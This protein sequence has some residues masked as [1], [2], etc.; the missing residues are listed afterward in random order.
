MQTENEPINTFPIQ[1]FIKIVK[2][3]DA[4][5]SREIKLDIQS[6]KNL[7]FTLGMVLARLNGDL[8]KLLVSKSNNDDTVLQISVDGGKSW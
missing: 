2:S 5:Q 1:N 8:E 3:A 6:A 7:A 4:S